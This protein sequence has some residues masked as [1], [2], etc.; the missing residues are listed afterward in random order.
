MLRVVPH[1]DYIALGLCILVHATCENV[2]KIWSSLAFSETTIVHS[3]QECKYCVYRA[4]MPVV[5]T[6]IRDCLPLILP[7]DIPK[8]VRDDLLVLSNSRKL[9]LYCRHLSVRRSSP[10]I[11]N[12]QRLTVVSLCW[13]AFSPLVL[14]SRCVYFVYFFSIFLCSCLILS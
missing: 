5:E 12:H 13:R 1:V 14:R 3:S 6:L 8:N 9:S 7:L 11:S 2:T 10:S 4:L